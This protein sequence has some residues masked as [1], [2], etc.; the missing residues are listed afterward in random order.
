[1]TI[2]NCRIIDG[3]GNPWFKA[4]IG[5]KKGKI[6]K[7][8]PLQLKEADKV[9]DARGLLVCPGF[10]N[11]HSHS[12]SMI[13]AHNKA[14]NCLAMGLVTELTG[15]CGSSVAPITERVRE[16]LA[17]SLREHTL[18]V[19]KDQVDWLTLDEWKKKLERKGI[20]INIAPLVGHGSVRSC[21]M[22]V[23][24]EGGERV[25]P[26]N[27][28]IVKMKNM[29][30]AAMNDGAFGLS[31]GLIYPPGRNALTD[32]IVELLKVVARYGGVYSSHMRCEGDRLLEA[33]REFIE[34]CDKAGV[35]GTIA[36]H[37]AMGSN[38][39]G[40]VCETIRI[41]ERARMRGIDVIIDQYPWRHG[42]TTKSLGA[43]FKGI[44]FD[45]GTKIATRE[46]LVSK[47]KDPNSW[48][49]IK[50]TIQEM[51]EKE[52]GKNVSRQKKFEE[53]GFWTS[54]FPST[55]I[56]T[57]LYSK[58]HRELEGKS[59]EELA[60]ALGEED[61]WEGIRAI[62]IA[63]EGYT[64][65]GGEPYSEDDIITILRYPWTTV[66]T[67]QYAIDNS[68]VTLQDA[69]N[70]L[71]MQHPRGWGT[72]PKILGKY[73]REEKVLTLEDAI[74]KMT[75]LP[76]RF[77]GLQDRGII[78]EGFWAD[79]VAFDPDSVGCQATYE[80]PNLFPKGIP[81]VLVNG[82]LAIEEGKPTGALGGK[83]LRLNV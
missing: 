23:E 77:L 3:T 4:N 55:L 30:E 68:K 60:K 66:S 25:V 74:R 49:K 32:E 6:A 38:N 47:L 24:D 20:G 80:N 13:M 71:S 16:T 19:M 27:D 48:E 43:Q 37:K 67:D 46:E 81:Y 51:Q 18:G 22:G 69:A 40:K 8:S 52:I 82:E 35:R 50:K 9:L 10:I 54:Q 78:K 45:D 73:V 58:S 70:A 83:V 75:S 39:Y 15:N 64:S 65:A 72:Y 21:V 5:V 36:H 33:T 62:L 76:A 7:I 44:Q 42:G 12:D 79:L 26:T 2:K 63:D 53:K 17:E 14:E 59:F 11:I 41:V 56:G 34:T 57:I 1:L 31:T 29:V 28:E 61:V